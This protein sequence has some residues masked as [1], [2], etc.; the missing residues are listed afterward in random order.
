MFSLFFLLSLPLLSA[1][2]S[3]PYPYGNVSYHIDCGGHTLA[4]DSF[5][6]TWLPD[7]FF[8]GGAAAVV[9]EPLH[10]RQP[11]E[12]TLR[13]FPLSSGKKNCYVV[14]DLPPGRY[15]VRTFIVY[16]NYDGKSHSPSF[17]AS[18]EGTLVFSWR[19]PWPSAI[20]RDGDSI[21]R[22]FAIS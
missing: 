15:Y 21:I 5:N 17:D 14:P 10:F 9:S 20:A 13:Y 7:R 3:T 2:T 16:D 6:T 22:P 12:K 19:S 8:T 18:V 11:Q 4:V 1:S